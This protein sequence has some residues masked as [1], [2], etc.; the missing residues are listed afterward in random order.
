MIKDKSIEE[1]FNSAQNGNM[2]A[3]EKLIVNNMNL[4]YKIANKYMYKLDFEEI[5]QVG[6]V[7]LIK[8][9]DKFDV[10]LGYKFSTYAVPTITSEILSYIRDTKGNLFKLKRSDYIMYSQIL[11][12]RSVLRQEFQGEPSNK[13]IAAWL[14]EDVKKVDMVINLLENYRSIDMKYDYDDNNLTLIEQIENPNDISEEQ[15][16]K[17]VYIENTL[18]QLSEKERKIIHFR[19]FQ[20]KTQNEISRIMNISQVQISRTEKLALKHLKEILTTGK[21]IS[22]QNQKRIININDKDLDKLTKRQRQ[23]A[24]LAFNKNY[25]QRQISEEL[26]ISQGCISGYITNI[27]KKL[28]KIS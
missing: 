15:I 8:A 1:L 2:E 14:D 21:Q 4:V 7:G 9:V 25:T 17:K 12:A 3:R 11:K 10:S 28:E 24:E 5:V 16:I 27:I 23:V 19:F 26:G 13:E 20:E 6:C 18:N 22:K